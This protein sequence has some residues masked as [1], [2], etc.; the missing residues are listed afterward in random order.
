[1]KKLTF[2]LL[3]VILGAWAQ[4]EEKFDPFQDDISDKYEAGL[5]LIYDCEEGHWVCVRE[6][7][8]KECEELRAQ[9][10][11][12]Q[13][14]RLKCA[15]IGAMASKRACYQRVLFLTTHNHGTRFC[16]N[17]KWKNKAY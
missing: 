7:F 6:P 9:G 5:H 14:A 10:L 13:A 2:L 17:D 11:L 12:K 3:F 15:P 16:I 4:E 1:M 8:Y